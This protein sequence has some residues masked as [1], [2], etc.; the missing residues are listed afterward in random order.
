MRKWTGSCSKI[1]RTTMC[2]YIEHPSNAT[3]T[4][5]P[6]WNES[7]LVHF[8][9]KGDRVEGVYHMDSSLRHAEYI[10]TSRK[11]SELTR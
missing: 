4:R 6:S 10:R 7:G 1:K 5:E 2:V 9:P 11:S 8:L 3:C